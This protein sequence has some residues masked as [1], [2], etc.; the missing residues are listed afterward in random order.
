MEPSDIVI[1]T[2]KGIRT[3]VRANRVTLEAVRD[4]VRANREAVEANRGAIDR[5]ADRVTD[6]EI[7]L[8]TGLTAMHGEFRKARSL[9]GAYLEGRH[10][11]DDHEQRIAALE[12]R[13]D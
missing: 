10:R 12:A 4:E 11:L 2:L 3:E 9:F 6:T 8:A 5:V 13:G 1:E 7:R